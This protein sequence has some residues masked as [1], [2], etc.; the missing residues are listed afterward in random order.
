MAL[1]VK[2]KVKVKVVCWDWDREVADWAYLGIGDLDVPWPLGV[3]R[4][5]GG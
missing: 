5:P 1:G 2:V 4:G 3:Y